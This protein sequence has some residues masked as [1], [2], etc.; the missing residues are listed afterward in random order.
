VPVPSWTRAEG[1][2]WLPEQARVRAEVDGV[3]LR[4]LAAPD[5]LV[6]AGDPLVETDDPSL[7]QE[8]RLL[9]AKRRELDARLTEAQ[10]RDRSQAQVVREE[11]KVVEA[12]LARA[13]ESLAALVL[14]SQVGGRFLVPGAADLPG[15]FLRRG[16]LVAYVAQP[17]AADVRVAVDQDDI[18]LVR[19]RTEAVQL[20]FADWEAEPVSSRITRQVPAATDQLPSRALGSA[21]GGPIAVDP[22]DGSGLTALEKVFVLDLE[23][24]RSAA[25]EY[26]GR[27]V[28]VR[29]DHGSEPLALQWFRSLRQLFLSRLGV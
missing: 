8:V 19:S 18:G 11:I 3:V 4:L 21:G 2:V 10:L 23:L 24:P 29:F 9:E 25:T 12:D 13:R 20:R 14:R 1:V 17:S 15:R 6:N 26:L 16:E 27:R 28:E 5:S 22:R 7:R